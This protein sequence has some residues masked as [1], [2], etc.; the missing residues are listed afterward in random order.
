MR[1]LSL[2]SLSRL[3]GV[4]AAAF[5]FQVASASATAVNFD[6]GS[7][8]VGNEGGNALENDAAGIGLAFA[9]TG[10]IGVTLTSGPGLEV[11]ATGQNTGGSSSGAPYAY[12]D[13]Y[14][15]GWPAGLGVCQVLNSSQDC[16][17]NNDDNITGT[18]SFAEM[19]TLTFSEAVLLTDVL[20]RDADHYS[21]TDGTFLLNGV[22]QSFG[23]SDFSS[24]GAFNVWSFE[25]EDTQFYVNSLTAHT[26]PEPAVAGLLATGLLGLALLRRRRNASLQ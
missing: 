5:L 7:F 19:L 15:A 23:T 25:F 8:A 17:P 4:A 13:A 9:S 12:L 2:R 18:S 24:L 11:L 1:T 20:F 14:D 26:V 21:L 16:S 10:L 6:F 22:S 3:A